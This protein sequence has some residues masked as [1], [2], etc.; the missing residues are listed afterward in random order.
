MI[1]LNKQNRAYFES[2]ARDRFNSIKNANPELSQNAII[3]IMANEL[4]MNKK[5]LHTRLCRFGIIEI[6]RKFVNLDKPISRDIYN[7]KSFIQQFSEHKY[8]H[9][10]LQMKGVFNDR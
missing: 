3:A 10:V 2:F 6:K 1:R 4:Q 5:T 7:R 8:L 9:G